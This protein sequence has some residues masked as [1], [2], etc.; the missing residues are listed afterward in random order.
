VWRPIGPNPIH[1]AG[2]CIDPKVFFDA[3]GRINSIAVAPNGNR[4]FVGSAGGGVWRSDDG[5]LTW[6]P[7]TD[8]QISLGIGSSHALALDPNN[9]Q[10][11]YAGT[12]NFGLLAQSLPRAI[13]GA[14]SRGLLKSADGGDSWVVLGSGVPSGN[15]GNA[16][17]TFSGADINAVIVDPADS[18]TLYVAAGRA[19]TGGLFRSTDGGRNW[20]A[21]AGQ[22]NI[23]AESLALDTSSPPSERV[24]YAGVK[25]VGVRKSTDGGKTWSDVF[26]ASTPALLPADKDFAKVI[27]ALAPTAATP[28]PKGQVVYVTTFVGVHGRIFESQDGGTTWERK[29]PTVTSTDTDFV[30]LDG[31]EF[32][33]MIV[34]PASPGDGV[35]DILYWG[36]FSQYV[37]TDSGGHFTEI[38][39]SHGTHGD[40]QAF[41]A[42]KK[43]GGVSV[44]YSADDGGIFK[45]TDQGKTWTGT[46]LSGSPATINA[47]G[48][49]TATLY[50][51]AVKPGADAGVTI[52][53]AQDSG[54]LRTNGGLQWS[55]TSND[56]I[57]VA[58]DGQDPTIAYSIQN[59]Q[60]GDRILKSTDSGATWA[61]DI[62]SNIPASARWTFRNRLAADPN[63][64]GYL[65]VG[66]SEGSLFLTKNGGSSYD[67]LGKPASGNY[68]LSAIDV[69][70]PDS[71]HVVIA[72]NMVETPDGH[73]YAP[74]AVPNHVF[75]TTNAL[76]SSVTFQDITRDLP[77]RFI[78]RVAFDP[79]DATVIYATVAGFDQ[80]TARAGHVFRTT[81]AGDAWTDISPKVDVPANAL[82]LDPGSSPAA[83]YVGT[84]LGVVVS[85]DGGASWAVVDDLHL[86]NA[87]VSDL[88]LNATVGV[89]RA[90]T[91][92]RG[93][94]ELG[95]PNGPAISVSTTR[96][97]LDGAC[98]GSGKDATIEVSNVGNQDLIVN[99]VLRS[100][101]PAAFQVLASPAVPLTLGAGQSATFTVRYTPASPGP[102]ESAVIRIVSSDPAVPFVDVVATGRMETTPPVIAALTAAPAVLWPPNHEMVPVTI[103]VDVSDNCDAAV[104]GS[105]HIVAVTSNEPAGVEGSGKTAP[106]W[107]ITGKLTLLLRGERSGNGT[108]RVYTVTVECTD[109]AGN[110]ATRTTTV[111]VPLE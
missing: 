44:L 56:G 3:N 77:P 87:A 15:D 26:T 14:Q 72:M 28:N 57:D 23:L 61:Q 11:I 97:T 18:Q 47:G 9:A 95:A 27:V 63:H 22:T 67:T 30:A 41:L 105:C 89:L 103:S 8:H 76:Q 54:M 69:A 106:D 110:H 36:G 34:D 21:G 86:P 107:A 46:S 82:V 74:Y 58:F 68:Y 43:P 109:G 66:G 10:T 94:F 102:R 16:L 39:Q 24:L 31:G 111:V 38:G 73:P 90:A 84:D 62:T 12:T 104:A 85:E 92:G 60:D 65:Y 101:G 96:L 49:Q 71:D 50:A 80:M 75:V 35:N 78:T 64:G 17:T 32:S 53:G 93:V 5:G 19:L 70:P 98:P 59:G 6:N 79:H 51:L 52:G 88:A 4:V 33:D 108:G 42:V 83:I 25:G 45:S 81:I 40:H 37:S 29:A 55:G 99:N 48:L 20:T 13:D 100:S 2:C 91:W 7:L 1:E